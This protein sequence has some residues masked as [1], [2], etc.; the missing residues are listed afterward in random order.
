MADTLLEAH[1]I[2][3]AA[4]AEGRDQLSAD[5]LRTIDRLYTG[6][7]ARA[8]IDNPATDTS[9]LAGHARTLAARFDIHRKAILRFT[10]SPPWASRTTW[11]SARS[12]P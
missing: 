5:E 6:A 11:R 8:R 10:T 1:R 12:D 7:L 2:A 9:V 3:T 4:R